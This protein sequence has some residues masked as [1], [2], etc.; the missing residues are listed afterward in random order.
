M[1]GLESSICSSHWTKI[2][3]NSSVSL[4]IYI[5]FVYQAEL[6]YLRKEAFVFKGVACPSQPKFFGQSRCWGAGP[7]PALNSCTNK[8]LPSLA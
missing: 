8:L 1:Q 4:A 6:T 2:A 5:F 7:T 3:H